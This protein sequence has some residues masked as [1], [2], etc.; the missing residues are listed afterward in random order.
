MRQDWDWRGGGYQVK[1]TIR[2]TV[3]DGPLRAVEAAPRRNAKHNTKLYRTRQATAG[4]PR[5]TIYD[6]NPWWDEKY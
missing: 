4:P 6:Y 3:L 1:G 5:P 2:A